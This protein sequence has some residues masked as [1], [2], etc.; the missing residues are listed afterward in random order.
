MIRNFLHYKKLKID[1]C[2]K[3]YPW[4]W[5]CQNII[6][7]IGNYS[8]NNL[9]SV[10]NQNLLKNLN[11]FDLENNCLKNNFIFGYKKIYQELNNK[12]NFLD[13]NY[14]SPS[15]SIALNTLQSYNNQPANLDFSNLSCEIIDI[16]IDC[17]SINSNNKILGLICQK[18][19]IQNIITGGI[20][21]EH[22]E[23][24]DYY[25]YKQTMRIIYKLPNRIDIWDWERDINF[26]DSEWQVSNINEII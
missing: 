11:E 24:W 9:S 20:G 22:K 26:K 19:L 14:T 16:H 25:F 23:I 18:E 8:K 10:N 7:K 12:I 4:G 6:K 17:Y 3:K 15:L 13:E 5:R 21:P 2:S 1:C